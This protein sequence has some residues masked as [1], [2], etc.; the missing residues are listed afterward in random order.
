M[1]TSESLKEQAQQAD[2]DFQAMSLLNKSL[3]EH[4]LEK[5]QDYIIPLQQR[6]YDVVESNHKYTIDT[7]TQDVQFGIIDYFPK[8]NKLLIRKD[9]K[10]VKPGLTWIHN[11]L[12]K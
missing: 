1:K 9:N 5:F 4:R 3:R 2:N 10:W 7:D 8:A 12:L 6:G 11:N